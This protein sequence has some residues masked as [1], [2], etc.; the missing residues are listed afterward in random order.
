[1]FHKFLAITA[2]AAIAAVPA[3]GH[4]QGTTTTLPQDTT[5]SGQH[6]RQDSSRIHQDTSAGSVST[7]NPNKQGQ[8][9]RDTTNAPRTHAD[10]L[11]A[12]SLRA[13]SLRTHTDS[14][15]NVSPADTTRMGAPTTQSPTPPSPTPPRD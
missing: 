7:E 15:M 4:A 11:R 3:T 5:Y 13:D 14:S 1:M 6:A 10:S 12:D 8:R 2:L 9:V